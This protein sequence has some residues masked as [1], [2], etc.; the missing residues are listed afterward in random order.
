MGI[1]GIADY[2]SKVNFKKSWFQYE[3]NWI[4]KN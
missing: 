3:K 2:K 1:F 4:E